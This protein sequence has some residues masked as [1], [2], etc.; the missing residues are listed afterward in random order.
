MT[1]GKGVN[2]FQSVDEIGR[3]AVNSIADDAFFTYGWFKTLETQQSF[4]ISPIYFAVYDE[5]QLVAVA[6]CFIDLL[7]H[8]FRYAPRVMPFNRVYFGERGSDFGNKLLAFALKKMLVFGRQFGFCRENVLLCYSP[9]SGRSKV[10]IGK[11]FEDEHLTLLIEKIDAFCK[12]EKVLFSSF[13]FVS[14]FNNLLMNSLPDFGYLKAREHLAN[15]Y[16]DVRWSSFGEYLN[17]MEYHTRKNVRR[18]IQKC[19]ENGVTIERIEIKGN[20]AH[21]LEIVTDVCLTQ[22][23]NVRVHDSDYSFLSKLSGYAKDKIILFIGKKNDQVVG[24]SLCLRK[25]DILDVWRAR[26]NYDV[27]TTTDFTYFNLCYYTP[28]RWAIDNN[29]KKI[30]YPRGLGKAKLYR[31]C[32]PENVFSFVRCHESLLEPLIMNLAKTSLLTGSAR[33]LSKSQDG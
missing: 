3:D 15:F 2:V 32:K 19:A 26:F 17:S 13:L 31:G 12:K 9:F 28:I 24:F 8:F 14:E 22:N 16:F 6:P 18:E 21:F 25:G 7:D 33:E 5:G 11:N 30:R 29:V 27:Q 4:R 23:R 10:L 1:L 20:Q